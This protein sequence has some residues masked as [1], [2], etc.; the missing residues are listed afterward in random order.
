M[1]VPVPNFV[2]IGQTVAEIWRLFDFSK[3]ATVR[4]LGSVM[5]VF[6]PATKG[7]D[8]RYHCAQLDWNRCSIFHNMQVL[9]FCDFGSKRPIHAPKIGFFEDLTPNI[10][11]YLI[12]TPKGH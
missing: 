8:D 10:G 6:A 9:I 1:C 2:A 12:V 5:R 3:I 11:G 7:I 4:H